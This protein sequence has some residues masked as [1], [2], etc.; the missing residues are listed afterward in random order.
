MSDF[1]QRPFAGRPPQY[2]HDDINPYPHEMRVGSHEEHP[3]RRNDARQGHEERRWHQG[4]QAP[5]E[6][7]GFYSYGVAEG[8]EPQGQRTSPTAGQSPR[9]PE[10]AP[11]RQQ[12]RSPESGA[13]RWTQWA[14]RAPQHRTFGK[15]PRNYQRS[16]AR[17]CE[18]IAEHIMREPSIDAS[19]VEIDVHGREVTLRGSVPDHRMK[20][21]IEGL[22]QDAVT[23]EHVENC[24]RVQTQSEDERGGPGAGTQQR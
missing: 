17:V 13:G 23:I 11:Y 4:N 15:C 19:D 7:E 10:E 1:T 22:A 18:D 9:Y 20:R 3:G 16:E 21:C 8:Y 6:P 12:S 24:L 5:G 14:K 2:A